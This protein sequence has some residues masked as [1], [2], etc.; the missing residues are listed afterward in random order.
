ME[1]CS[2]GK[3]IKRFTLLATFSI[4]NCNHHVTFYTNDIY[5]QV[6]VCTF[7]PL[8]PSCPSTSSN[9]ESI[10]CV[11]SLLY[12]FCLALFSEST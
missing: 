5:S 12:V 9:H 7:D 10:L 8:Y 4:V 3:K 2:I 1:E 11:S 6:V